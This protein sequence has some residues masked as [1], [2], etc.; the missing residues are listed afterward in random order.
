MLS[1]G[2][3]ARSSAKWARYFNTLREVQRLRPD[4]FVIENVPGILDALEGQ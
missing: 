1:Q 2:E 4:V 3:G